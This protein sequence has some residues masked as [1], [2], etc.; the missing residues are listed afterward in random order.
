M[1][2]LSQAVADK[3]HQEQRQH[4]HQSF[5]SKEQRSA[6]QKQQN[7]QQPH[8]SK[9]WPPRNHNNIPATRANNLLLLPGPGPGPSRGSAHPLSPPAPATALRPVLFRFCGTSPCTSDDGL[10]L[11]R[12]LCHQILWLFSEDYHPA[13]QHYSSSTTTTSSG[14]DP[15]PSQEP[16][17]A[18]A[19]GTGPLLPTV[20]HPSVPTAPAVPSTYIEAVQ[21]L[22]TLLER[23]AVILFLDGLEALSD[24][25][26]ARSTVSFLRDLHPHPGRTITPPSITIHHYLPSQSHLTHSIASV[27]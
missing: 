3:E 20:V 17:K 10:S 1:A 5:T 9:Q 2:K 24:V 14:S 25:H 21:L 27:F 7:Q 11:V 15:S 8:P 22:H 6:T 13:S 12:G 19:G 23:H 26:G 4:Q 18:F 16:S